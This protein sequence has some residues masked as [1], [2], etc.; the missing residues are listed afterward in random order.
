MVGP[1]YDGADGT[2][3]VPP[4]H[5]AGP[6]PFG[7]PQPTSTDVQ[8]PNE[9]RRT[10][11]H[12]T[13]QAASGAVTSSSVIVESAQ[14]CPT[15]RRLVRPVGPPGASAPRKTLRH[16]P[17]PPPDRGT[18]GRLALRLSAAAIEAARVNAPP[19][20]PAYP[21]LD[22]GDAGYVS[23]LLQWQCEGRLNARKPH[24]VDG[25]MSSKLTRMEQ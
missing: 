18:D 20:M 1:G 11:L 14:V 24:E 12:R 7:P 21:R 17:A 15:G 22:V 23:T 13:S 10:E 8:A 6:R 5:A 3:S 9:W 19:P 25:G 2:P 16:P 4:V